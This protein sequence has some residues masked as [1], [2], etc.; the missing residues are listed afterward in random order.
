LFAGTIPAGFAFRCRHVD[1]TRN[2]DLYARNLVPTAEGVVQILLDQI[3][4]TLAGSPVLVAGYGKVGKTVARL[5]AAL[6]AQVS[7]YSIDP[8]EQNEIGARYASASLADLA[9]F[10]I[11]VNTIPAVVFD[12]RNLSTLPQE[13]L[14][15]DVASFPGGVDATLAA[16]SGLRLLRAYGIPGKKAPRTVAESMRDV[17]VEHIETQR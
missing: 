15:L 11:V 17:I 9:A 16:S 8:R 4:F 3:D 13:A 5:L 12:A 14:L 10:R 6:D 2:A 7:V 1:L